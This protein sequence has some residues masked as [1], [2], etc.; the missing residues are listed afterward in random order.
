MERMLLS[1]LKKDRVYALFVRIFR[2]LRKA[3]GIST[4][5]CYN[6]EIVHNGQTY[7]G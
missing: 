1:P 2:E 7:A 5:F 4:F 6:Y 3:V